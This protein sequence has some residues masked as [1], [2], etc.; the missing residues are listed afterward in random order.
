[1]WKVYLFE[2]V[3]VLVVSI[4]WVHVLEKEKNDEDN[5]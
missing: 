4:L 3:V 2:F 5:I 1:M